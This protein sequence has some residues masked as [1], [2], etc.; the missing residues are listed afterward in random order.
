MALYAPSLLLQMGAKA[1]KAVT[2]TP[3]AGRTPSCTPV[4]LAFTGPVHTV[5]LAN[6]LLVCASGLKLSVLLRCSTRRLH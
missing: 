2:G 1:P 6:F 3:D 4:M 5:A